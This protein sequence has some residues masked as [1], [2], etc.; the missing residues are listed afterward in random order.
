MVALVPLV[1]ACGCVAP[2]LAPLRPPPPTGATVDAT[3]DATADGAANTARGTE[4][5]VVPNAVRPPASAPDSRSTPARP[6]SVRDAATDSDVVATAE[7]VFGAEPLEDNGEG[8]A[9]VP[10]WDL[11]VRSYETHQSVERFLSLYRGS[12]RGYTAARLSRGTRFEPMIRAKFRAA[13]MPEDLYYLAFVES[14]FDV[15]AMSRAGA[16]GL[17]QFTAGTAR[18]LGLRVTWWVDDR[19]DPARATDAAVQYLSALHQQFG[20]YYLAAAAYNAG[21][22]AVSRGLRQ[23]GTALAGS[24]ADTPAD[25]RFF[26]LSDRDLLRAETR[27]FVPQLIAV[28]LVAKDSARFGLAIV[29]TEPLAYDSVLVEPGTSLG[30]LA[31]AAMLPRDVLTEL[32]PSLLRGV[33]PPDGA[34]WIRVPVGTDSVVRHAIDS[35]AP[36]ERIGWRMEAPVP[37]ETLAAFAKRVGVTVQVL[38]W[39]NPGVRSNGAGVLMGSNALRVPTAETI[40]AARAIPNVPTDAGGSSRAPVRTHVVKRGESLGVIAERYGT[41]VNALKRANGLKSDRIRAGQRLRI[42]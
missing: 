5:A 23:L 11:N 2:V 14:A 39:F 41:T 9:L 40:E 30:A 24:L 34:E 21:P 13:G 19:R 25:D 7:R 6:D 37:R 22:V 17:W 20:S 29:P 15:H 33:A 1:V 18:S 12:R 4:T 31:R 28:A 42:G 32:N 8:E 35:L 10:E 36:E 16:G 26:A 3:V 27:S 38:R